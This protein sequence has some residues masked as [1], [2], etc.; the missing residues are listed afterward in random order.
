MASIEERLAVIEA[1]ADSGLE[2]AQKALDTVGTVTAWAEDVD[3]R[4]AQIKG[5]RDSTVREQ[6]ADL[7]SRLEALE[8]VNSTPVGSTAVV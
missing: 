6:I 7:R 3:V 5:R 2:K 4:L 8:G 1:K